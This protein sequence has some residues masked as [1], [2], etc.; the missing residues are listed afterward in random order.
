M[1]FMFFRTWCSVK[2]NI[3]WPV[4]DHISITWNQLSIPNG[5]I[6]IIES[7]TTVIHLFFFCE[8]YNRHTIYHIRIKMFISYTIG[9]QTYTIAGPGEWIEIQASTLLPC[10]NIYSTSLYRTILLYRN[11]RYNS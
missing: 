6:I 1:M 5:N 3:M 8:R 10:R 4:M 11:R 7:L 9:V 2:S